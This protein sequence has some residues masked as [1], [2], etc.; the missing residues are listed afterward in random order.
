MSIGFE[1]LCEIERA[2]AYAAPDAGTVAALRRLAPG[3][4]ITRCDAAD[5]KDETPFRSYAQCTLY[6]LDGRDHCVKITADL[7]HATGLILAPKGIGA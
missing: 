3:V 7:A 4:F 1:Q 6:L 2:L 5:V